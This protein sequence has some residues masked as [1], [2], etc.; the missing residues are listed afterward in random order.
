MTSEEPWLNRPDEDKRRII[1][2]LAEATLKAGHTVV[3]TPKS[4]AALAAACDRDN[5]KSRAHIRAIDDAL[6]NLHNDPAGRLMIFMPP[7]AGKS[8]LGARWLPVWWLTQH[9]RDAVVITSYSAD[10][11]QAH[12]AAARDLLQAYGAP[13]GLRIGNESTRA[14]WTTTAGGRV[15]SMG[16]GGPLTGKDM[17]LGIIDDPFKDRAEADSPI[18][19]ERVWAWY[20]AVFASRRQLGTRRLVINTRWHEDDLC[21]RILKDQGRIEDGGKWTVLHLPAIAVDEDRDRGFYPDPLGREPGQPLT[22]PDYAD[23]DIASLNA[24]WAEAHADSVARDWNA[25]YQGSPFD[26]K[27]A[28]LTDDNVR[29][30]TVEHLPE[31]RRTA[32]GVDPSGGGRDTAGIVAGVLGVDGKLYWTHDRTGRMTSDKWSEAACLLA[33]EVDADRIIVEKNFGGDMAKTLIRQAW[34]QLLREGRVPKDRL[35]PYV[36]EVLARKS[37]VLRAEPIAQAV[38]TG[39]AKFG[40][41]FELKNLKGE[42]VRWEPGSTWSP[43]ALDAAVH[44][45]TDLLP[46]IAAGATITS[47]ANRKR[48]DTGRSGSWTDRRRA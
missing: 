19:R 42:W 15:S 14:T 16:V 10:L 37:K 18:M 25:M 27:G 46:P 44:L 9:P 2:D 11:A 33:A 6:V 13:Y 35:C 17:K 30:A 48:D 47:V 22:H 40:P 32:I 34:D 36:H 24:H 4:P 1:A 21:G 7:R 38:K 20:S 31:A 26:A 45:A 39:R 29:D 8:Q 3:G 12:G 43:G 5:F 41:G 28:L 23:S